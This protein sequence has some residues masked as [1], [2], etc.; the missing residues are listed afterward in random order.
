MSNVTC[1]MSN[2]TCHMSHVTCQMSHVTCQNVDRFR[3]RSLEYRYKIYIIYIG[4]TFV[5]NRSRT[6]DWYAYLGNPLRDESDGL[7][8]P[9]FRIKKFDKHRI[10]FTIWT[11]PCHK[12]VGEGAGRVP[13]PPFRRPS[14]IARPNK[15]NQEPPNKPNQP[16]QTSQ[17]KPTKAN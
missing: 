6:S 4:F 7:W 5:T 12:L 1:H 10:L 13:S 9:H 15:P 8:W 17:T 3:Y 2:V 14:K 16:K 11:R